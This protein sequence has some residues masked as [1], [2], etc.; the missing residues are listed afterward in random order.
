MSRTVPGTNRFFTNWRL[1][2]L[3]NGLV[4]FGFR[5]RRTEMACFSSYCFWDFSLWR[6]TGSWTS[7]PQF[8]T[9][10]SCSSSSLFLS[11]RHACK[12][13]SHSCLGHMP[14]SVSQAYGQHHPALSN[15]IVP[16]SRSTCVW[17]WEPIKILLEKLG[18]VHSIPVFNVYCVFVLW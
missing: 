14:A 1:F 15:V 5:W 17:T 10:P 4:F 7:R 16:D 3:L 13:E 8:W 12:S 18:I 6:Q 11:V 2:L 9:S